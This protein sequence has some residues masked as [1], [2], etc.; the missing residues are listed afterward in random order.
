MNMKIQKSQLQRMMSKI[1]W[2]HLFLLSIVFFS[3]TMQAQITLRTENETLRSV[4]KKIESQTDFTFFYNEALSDLE[5]K[6]TFNVTNSG[7]DNVLNQLLKETN[8]A[9]SIQGK[10]IAITVKGKITPQSDGIAP[11]SAAPDK[12]RKVSAFI[13]C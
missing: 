4:M 13:I 2:K 3:L 11:Q 10:T 9:Y 1:A 12:V 7:I 8:L 6:V 5:K